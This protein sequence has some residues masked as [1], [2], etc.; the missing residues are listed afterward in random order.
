MPQTRTRKTGAIDPARLEHFGGARPE[1]S[2]LRHRSPPQIS[3]ALGR[4]RGNGK[5]AGVSCG[6][7]CF[8][9]TSAGARPSAG[10]APPDGSGELAGEGMAL[11]LGGSS[12]GP[13]HAAENQRVDRIQ[14]MPIQPAEQPSRGEETPQAAC[15][16]SQKRLQSPPDE[17][18]ARK[19]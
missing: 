4:S 16:P 12:N 1:A 8:G 5:A 9:A 17:P 19:A 2:I 14:P 13:E 10:I 7:S 3:G 18:S 6:L 11:G 15:V